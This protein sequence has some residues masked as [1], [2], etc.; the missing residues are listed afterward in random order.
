MR[1]PLARLVSIGGFPRSND[2]RSAALYQIYIV[3]LINNGR[4]SVLCFTGVVIFA[5]ERTTVPEGMFQA[6]KIM[7]AAAVVLTYGEEGTIAEAWH[8]ARVHRIQNE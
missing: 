7:K 1:L 3:Y 4:T 8:A 2:F 5:N 6:H